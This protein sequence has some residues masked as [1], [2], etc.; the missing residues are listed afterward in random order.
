MIKNRTSYKSNSNQNFFNSKFNSSLDLIKKI[1]SQPEMINNFT[2]TN[3]SDD[4]NNE[5]DELS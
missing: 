4:K 3:L 1:H 2:V 5:N